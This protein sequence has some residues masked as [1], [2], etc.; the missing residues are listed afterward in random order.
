MSLPNHDPS[1]PGTVQPSKE[2]VGAAATDLIALVAEHLPQRFYPSERPW[3][4]YGPAMIARMADIVGSSILLMEAE[5][6]MDGAVLVRVLYEHVVMAGPR[7]SVHP[8]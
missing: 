2:A 7:S 8:W 5:R 6:I 4:S 1:A 3:R